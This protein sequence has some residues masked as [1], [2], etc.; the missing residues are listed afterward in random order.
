VPLGAHHTVSENASAT[1]L[2][3]LLAIFV[4]KIGEKLTIADS[5]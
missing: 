1:K 5:R 3:R 4:V 2:A